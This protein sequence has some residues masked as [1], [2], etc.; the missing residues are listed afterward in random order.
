MGNKKLLDNTDKILFEKIIEEATTDCYNEYE[1][2][3]GWACSLVENIPVPCKCL[4][5]KEKPL[6]EKIDTNNNSSEIFGIIR[7]N[8]TELRIPIE[9]IS[10][11][12]S[13]YM[14]YIRAYRYWR[15][16]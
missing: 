1:Q 12:N 9:D 13:G 2:I 8:K 5:G 11:E 16:C 6:L 10:L 14:K 4:I 15:K 7:L 3:A